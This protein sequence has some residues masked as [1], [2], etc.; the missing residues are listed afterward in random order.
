MLICSPSWTVLSLAV[1]KPA[2]RS[3]LIPSQPTMHGLPSPLVTTAAWLVTPPR[4]VTTPTA[5]LIPWISSG[6]VSGRTK[7]TA[8]PASANSAALV[9][10]KQTVPE[11]APGEAGAP[12]ARKFSSKTSLG[13]SSENWGTSRW[14]ISSASTLSSAWA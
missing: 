5:A 1:N 9:A 11:A 6:L 2:S 13:R 12:R 14:D 4:L 7:I 10:S 8:T 3:T